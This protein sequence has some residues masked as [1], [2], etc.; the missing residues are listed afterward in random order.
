MGRVRPKYRVNSTVGRKPGILIPDLYFYDVKYRPILSK[1]DKK[2][3]CAGKIVKTSDKNKK[4]IFFFKKKLIEMGRTRPISVG[5][6]NPAHYQNGLVTVPKHSNQPSFSCKR[7]KGRRAIGERDGATRDYLRWRCRWCC[8]R[9]RHGGR[10]CS[11][12][13]SLS[14]SSIVFFALFYFFF[15]SVFF[16]SFPFLFSSFMLCSLSS[17]PLSWSPFLLFPSFH[18]A[19][20]PCFYRQKQGGRP[21]LAA[22]PPS[23]NTW[24]AGQVGVPFRRLFEGR[25]R[26][27][28]GERGGEQKKKK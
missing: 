15:F 23:L 1:I 22:P 5:W 20:L 11:V 12:S 19:A 4:K 28:E 24:K 7:K 21:L 18:L 3:K 14:T 26:L 27:I 9:W 17:S 16:F 13:L 10:R 8:W 25:W 6:A 2:K